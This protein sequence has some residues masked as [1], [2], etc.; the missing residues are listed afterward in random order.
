MSHFILFSENGRVV[1]M[2]VLWFPVPLLPR[3]LGLHAGSRGNGEGYEPSCS[4]GSWAF[5]SP[6]PAESAGI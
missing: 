2:H 4:T 3:Q 1:R 5:S 6:L